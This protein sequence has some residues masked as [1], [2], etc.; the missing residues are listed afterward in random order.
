MNKTDYETALKNL[1]RLGDML[2]VPTPASERKAEE[3]FQ[4]EIAKE[5]KDGK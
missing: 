4:R 5:T 3:R 2:I 1:F